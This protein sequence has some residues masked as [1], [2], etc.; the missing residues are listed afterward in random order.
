[1]QQAVAGG[2]FGGPIAQVHWLI[3]E[4]QKEFHDALQHY[5]ALDEAILGSLCIQF[6]DRFLRTFFSL[7]EYPFALLTTH[8][9]RSNVFGS[10]GNV[11][12][13]RGGDNFATHAR[14]CQ[15]GE[16]DARLGYKF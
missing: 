11:S 2:L 12:I 15:N 16:M 9:Y 8:V 5:P 4:Y 1:L 14:V 10:Q 13:E 7:N 6:P 3:Q